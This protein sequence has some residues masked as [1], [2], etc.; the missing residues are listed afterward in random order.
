MKE[1][2]Y[3]EME[4]NPF[5]LLGKNGCWCLQVMSRMGVTR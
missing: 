1:I 3:K 5:N 4:F 2:D